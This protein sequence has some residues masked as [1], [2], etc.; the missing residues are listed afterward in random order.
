MRTILTALATADALGKPFEQSRDDRARYDWCHDPGNTFLACADGGRQF[1][2]GPDGEKPGA[3]TDD[4]QM[5]VALAQSLVACGGFDADD[6]RRRYTAWF[7]GEG[8][9]GRARGTGGT[10]RTALETGAPVDL[11]AGGQY[12]GNGAAMRVA[13]IGVW[14]RD[15]PAGLI[16][17]ARADARL[18]HDSPEAEAGSVAVAVAIASRMRSPKHDDNQATARGVWRDVFAALE[19][20]GSKYV[21]LQ[22]TAVY[23]ILRHAARCS[24]L[25]FFAVKGNSEFRSGGN[26][27]D[28]VATAMLAAMPNEPDYTFE[29]TVC[30]A[31]E[32]GGDTDTRAAIA[33]AIHAAREGSTIPA[34]WHGVEAREEL[35]ALDARLW[36]RK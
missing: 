3:F 29:E 12:V 17:A 1:G 2:L 22:Y 24:R 5:A 27:A 9:G 6:V 25:P 35:L 33:A 7:R 26:V 32:F 11:R 8:F 4:T 15:D 18:T 21:S 30:D 28:T 23:A 34:R 36:A 31:I 14:F 19:S 13:P 10:I 20:Q 16:A